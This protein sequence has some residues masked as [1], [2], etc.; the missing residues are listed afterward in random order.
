MAGGELLVELRGVTKDYHALRPLRVQHLELRAGESIALLG[1][2]AAMSEVLVNLITG[3]QLPDEGQVSVFGR[4]TSS[5]TA[6]DDWVAELDRFGLIS[7]R[8]VLV[9]Q[10]T[11]EQN[12]ALPISLEIDDM[13]ASVHAEVGRLASEVGLTADELT[14]P[15][16]AL[17]PAAQLRLR[18]GRALA[19]SPRVLLAEHPNA[20]LSREESLR[21]AKDFIHMTSARRLASLVMTVDATFASAVAD[22]VLEFQ[23]ATGALKRMSSWRRWFA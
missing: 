7:D 4:P 21:F 15:T 3:G 6:V 8:A 1:I 23:P 20:S 13:P 11:T 12:L 10:F 22:R 5:I 19:M 16:A 17:G 14:L 18:V 9:E 2:D